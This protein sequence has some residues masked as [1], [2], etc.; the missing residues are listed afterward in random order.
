MDEPPHLSI[1]VDAARDAPPFEQIRTQ[2]V[3]LVER[4]ELSAGTRLPTVRQIAATCG[5]AVNTAARAYRELEAAAVV[6]TRG[7]HGTFVA[8]GDD[9]RGAAADAAVAYAARIRELG[10]A[11]AEGMRLASHAL[12]IPS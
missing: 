7:R 6:E 5:V 12:G 4:G 3:A 2:I 9:A 1:V 11:P 8:A 10:I